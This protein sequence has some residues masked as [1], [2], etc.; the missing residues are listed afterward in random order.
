MKSMTLGLTILSS[1]SHY[2][3]SIFINVPAIPTRRISW[4]PDSWMGE[5]G[6]FSGVLNTKIL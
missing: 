4:I 3:V 5:A 6:C 2:K 1:S